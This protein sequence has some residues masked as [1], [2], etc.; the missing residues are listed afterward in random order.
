M[1]GFFLR[2]RKFIFPAHFLSWVEKYPDEQYSLK[3]TF[4][5]CSDVFRTDGHWILRNSIKD[6]SSDLAC[7]DLNDYSFPQRPDIM[8]FF[9]TDS[10]FKDSRIKGFKGLV[11]HR[12]DQN[13]PVMEETL[14]ELGGTVRYGGNFVYRSMNYQL[15]MRSGD[16]GLPIFI[17]DS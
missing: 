8:K 3:S 12:L 17:A 13:L 4:G 1:H 5:Y 16:C 7:F 6:M 11:M 10:T 2:E 15:A 9:C 14:V